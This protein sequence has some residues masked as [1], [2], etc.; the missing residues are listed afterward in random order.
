MNSDLLIHEGTYQDNMKKWALLNL[1]STFSEAITMGKRMNAKFT[2][3]THFSQRYWKVPLFNENFDES[4]G[5]AFDNMRVCDYKCVP[6]SEH[7]LIVILIFC[8]ICFRF[9]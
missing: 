9:V 7:L 6:I 2:I 5:V 3:L 8:C 1:H 4:V